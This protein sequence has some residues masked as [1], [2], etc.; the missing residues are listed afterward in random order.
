MKNLCIFISILLPIL[1]SGRLRA[2]EYTFSYPNILPIPDYPSPAAEISLIVNSIPGNIVPGYTC[3]PT[4]AISPDT[5]PAIMGYNTRIK[6]ISIKLNHP[7]ATDIDIELIA[8]NGTVFN[9]TTDNGGITGFQTTPTLNFSYTATTPITSWTGG[10]PVGPYLWEDSKINAQS[11]P[12][13]NIGLSTMKDPGGP[14]VNGIWKFKIKDDTQSSGG[15]LYNLSIV[16]ETYIPAPFDASICCSYSNHV[17]IGTLYP[18]NAKLEIKGAS[19]GATGSTT[20]AMGTDGNGISFQRNWPTIGFNQ[21]RD[22]NNIPRY[23]G[24]GKASLLYYDPSA[25]A[26]AWDMHNTSGTP[27]QQ[28]TGSG[29]RAIT[30]LDNGN[31]G[32]RNSGSASNSLYVSRL[33]NISGSAIF[34]GSTHHSYFAWNTQEDT[35]IRGGKDGSKVFI[36]DFYSPILRYGRTANGYYPDNNYNAVVANEIWGS[37]ALAKSVELDEYYAVTDHSSYRKISGSP[38]DNHEILVWDGKIDGQI[39][40]IECVG[41]YTLKLTNLY[42]NIGGPVN[43]HFYFNQETISGGDI[44]TM[45]WNA[46]R[47]KW[48][49]VKKTDN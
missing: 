7:Y 14:T 48:M 29:V 10:V 5:F 6:S 15:I 49:L 41:D 46:D 32:I 21:Y 26:F 20:A 38:T 9:I 12:T 13:C 34:L 44:I 23:M 3:S 31:I 16:F 33:G 35:Y 25:G 45:I 43:N 2:Q 18:S 17:G 11:V 39:I 24:A 42:P 1:M 19:G 47:G 37:A 22:A 27:D 30:I 28:I 36:N 40:V 8:P 4:E